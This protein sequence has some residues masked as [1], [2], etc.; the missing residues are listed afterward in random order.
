[1]IEYI[2]YIPQVEQAIL[3]LLTAV[4]GLAQ[5]GMSL[6]QRN[7]LQNQQQ[8]A[9]DAFDAQKKIYQ[10]LDTSN[11]YGN[12]RNRFQNLG[13]AYEGVENA[14]EDLTVNTQAAEFAAQQ[15]QQSAANILQ[16]M[17]GAAGG[18]G[19]GALAQALANQQTQA[20]QQASASIGQQ[21][22]RNKMQAAS[23]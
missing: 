3:P 11:V 19:I 18:S 6:A 14:F 22:A 4:G 7:K 17:S 9:Q 20:A 16:D 8:E 10:G 2:E 12:V 1:M 23:A 5:V 21:E 15:S 13:N